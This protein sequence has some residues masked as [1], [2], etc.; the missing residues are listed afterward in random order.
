[1]PTTDSSRVL[2][3]PAPPGW[4]ERA[5]EL[6]DFLLTSPVWTD[7]LVHESGIPVVDVPFLTVG[8][9]MGSF[10]MIDCLRI[11][12]V[13]TNQM[14]VLTNL[15]HPWE[16]Y[17]YLTGVSQL[18]PHYRIR[19]DASSMPDNIWGFPSYAV[20]R[21]FRSRSPRGFIAPLWNVLTENVFTDYWTP[22]AGEVFDGMRREADRVGYWDCVAHGQARM[23]RRRA[24]GGY[25]T[26]FT[27]QGAHKQRVVYRSGYVHLAVGYPSI[28]F[29]PDMQDYRARHGSGHRFVNAYEPHEQVYTDL[30]ARPGTVVVRGGGIAASAIIHRLLNDREQH[31]AATRIVHL[32]RTYVD[33][34]H[35]PSR[36][37]RR[38]GR[39]GWAHQGFNWPK[40]AWGGQL[41]VR[42]EKLEG[43]DRRQL[44]ELMAGSTTPYRRGWQ[45][46]L[47]QARRDGVYTAVGG[48]IDRVDRAEDDRLAIVYRDNATGT[49]RTLAADFV[50][51]ATG[52][53]GDLRSHRL[54]H[55]L[56]EVS[57]AARNLWGRLDVSP[58]FE[59]RSLRNGAGRLFAAGA[60]TE[61]AYYAPAD[62]LLGLQYAALRV[63]DQ[64][65]E[66]GFCHRI[67]SGRSI[68]QWCRRMRGV[69]P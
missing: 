30:V 14:K 64:L 51:D 39:L 8:G 59:V 69:A 54:L 52:L 13:P 35:G 29:L 6:P 11:A 56:V 43:E 25:F 9:G 37:M 55:D 1:M 31:G 18:P 63:T 27:T 44:W 19:S 57:G 65:A 7:E 67:G 28:R 32:L 2:A 61:G 10:A 50:V 42:L 60:V 68:A 38:R 48:V 16:N 23:V 36:F 46:Q 21:A 4:D 45:R 12:G 3:P 41:K 49:P 15:R 33:G 26:V 34:P 66:L 17:A 40:A 47:A 22:L 5:P 62:S 58:G 24:G 20:R 53:I